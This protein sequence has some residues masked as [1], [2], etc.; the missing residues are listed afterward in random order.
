MIVSKRDSALCNFTNF[1]QQWLPFNQQLRF[2]RGKDRETIGTYG[3]S[4]RYDARDEKVNKEEGNEYEKELR[5]WT[6]GAKLVYRHYATLF[7]IFVCEETESELGIL[8]L[9]QVFVETLDRCFE[10]V[11]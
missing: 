7:F 6:A 10:H 4:L 5:K 1:D 2:K 11:W 9:I 3:Q 8:D